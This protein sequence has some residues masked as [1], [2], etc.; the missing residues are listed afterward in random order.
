MAA[1]PDVARP[2]ARLV[3]WP[4]ESTWIAIALG[5][6]QNFG[7]VVLICALMPGRWT[8]MCPRRTTTVLAFMTAGALGSVVVDRN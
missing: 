6:L 8:V 5:P 7:L 1:A 2:D 3:L 4:F